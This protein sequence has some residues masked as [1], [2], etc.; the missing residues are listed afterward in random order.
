MLSRYFLCYFRPINLT[1]ATLSVVFTIVSNKKCRNILNL[2][3]WLTYIRSRWCFVTKSFPKN[4]LTNMYGNREMLW[5]RN[6]IEYID[7]ERNTSKWI[8]NNENNRFSNSIALIKYFRHYEDL[9]TWWN[10][11]KMKRATKYIIVITA[12]K[13]DRYIVLKIHSIYRS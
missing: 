1:A 6:N 10:I 8:V 13:I 7:F 11:Y 12:M 3:L 9:K 5:A 4:V 2:E